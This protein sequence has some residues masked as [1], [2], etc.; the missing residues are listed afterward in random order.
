MKWGGGLGLG[1]ASCGLKQT[2]YRRRRSPSPTTTSL[3]RRLGWSG[4]YRPGRLNTVSLTSATRPRGMASTY[5]PT[6]RASSKRLS[7]EFMPASA[8]KIDR[9]SFQPRKSSLIRATVVTSTVFPGKTQLLTGKPSR[10]TAKATTTWGDQAPSLA[11]PSRR[12]SPLSSSDVPL[13][14]HTNLLKQKENFKNV[15]ATKYL[16]DSM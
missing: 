15:V 10:V 8:T 2:I 12:R 4:R 9:P 3:A 14:T 13:R 7:S 5:F 16:F 1:L 6:P 11:W